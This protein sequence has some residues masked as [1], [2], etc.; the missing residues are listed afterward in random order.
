MGRYEPCCLSIS[1]G[2]RASHTFGCCFT[3]LF[4]DY[5]RSIQW[6]EGLELDPPI[7]VQLIN[8][9]CP[10]FNLFC[11]LSLLSPLSWSNH[12]LSSQFHS[13]SLVR[14]PLCPLS[15]LRWSCHRLLGLLCL[16]PSLPTFGDRRPHGLYRALAV[17]HAGDLGA[18]AWPEARGERGDR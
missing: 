8:L 14:Y 1:C 10:L 18:V 4:Q 12:R 15:I 17:R 13:L 5:F 16:L 3:K 9:F 11:F 2:R 7:Q 6:C